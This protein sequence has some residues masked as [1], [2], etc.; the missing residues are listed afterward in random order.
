MKS[1]F[2]VIFKFTA[3]IPSIAKNAPRPE[4]STKLDKIQIFP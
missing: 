2:D 4:P 1:P 3:Y